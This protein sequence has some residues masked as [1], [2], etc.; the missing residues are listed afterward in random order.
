MEFRAYSG[1]WSQNGRIA[2]TDFI[3]D[4]PNGFRT[5]IETVNATAPNF[6]TVLTE[7]NAEG[8]PDWSPDG[9]KIVFQSRRDGNHEINV[10]QWI[11]R[12]DRGDAHHDDGG[13]GVQPC[14]VA[15]RHQ[16]R[17]RARG[18]L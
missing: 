15:G 17:L 16:D 7:T 4:Y 8:E 6:K 3:N 5:N 13:P 10:N 9:T 1:S 2:Y 14:V 18:R 12:R 11:S